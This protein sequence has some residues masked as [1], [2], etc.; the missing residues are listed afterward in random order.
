M[1]TPSGDLLRPPSPFMLNSLKH[2]TG[3]TKCKQ[4]RFRQMAKDYFSGTAKFA[5]DCS[6]LARRARG[7][8]QR[9]RELRSKKSHFRSDAVRRNTAAEGIA[10]LERRNQRAQIQ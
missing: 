4:T 5:L 3:R 6:G 8:V 7:S 10:E 1:T 2:S 9:C